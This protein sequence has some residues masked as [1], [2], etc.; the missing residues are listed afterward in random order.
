ML[1][2]FAPTALGCSDVRYLFLV[3]TSSSA[4]VQ[5]SL[6]FRTFLYRRSCF[7][8]SFQFLVDVFDFKNEVL[9]E[10]EESDERARIFKGFGGYLAIVNDYIADGSHSEVNIDFRTKQDILKCAK[11]AVYSSLD[12]VRESEGG[13]R[14]RESE[15]HIWEPEAEHRVFREC[16]HSCEKDSEDRPARPFSGQMCPTIQPP[17]SDASA[18]YMARRSVVGGATRKTGVRVTV[19]RR[20]KK[21][22]LSSLMISDPVDRLRCCFRFRWALCRVSEGS[23]SLLQRRRFPRFSWT[24]F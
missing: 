7:F 22:R 20:K 1:C 11:F 5:P 16:L 6:P 17:C 18:C 12:M 3:H 19:R 8:Q 13:E 21:N 10:A 24:T 9:L 15:S 23:F 2:Y 14:E 4:Y